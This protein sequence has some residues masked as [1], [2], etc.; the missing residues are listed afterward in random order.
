MRILLLAA[1]LTLPAIGQEGAPSPNLVANPNLSEGVYGP[2]RWGLNRADA[3]HVDWYQSPDGKE[4]ALRLQGNGEDWAGATSQAVPAKPGEKLTVAAWIRSDAQAS[5][6]DRLFVRFFGETGFCGQQG[7]PIPAGAT[8][9]RLVS[10][11]VTVPD[12]A[13]RADV[14]LQIWSAGTVWLHSAGLF[15]GDRV[16]AGALP[17]PQAKEYVPVELPRGKPADA[18][19]NGLPDV[20]EQALEI[21]P[22]DA[23]RS[24][25]LT[26]PRNTSFQTPTGYREDNDLKVDIVIVAGNGEQDL[27]SWRDFGYEPHCMGGFRDG[28]AYVE[29][30]PG[31]PQMDAAG[32]A[33]TCGPGSYYLVPTAQRRQIM[34]KYFADAIRHGSRAACPEEPE[35]FSRAGYSPAFKAEWQ[36]A[37][38]EPW[39]DQTSSVDARLKSERLKASLEQQLLSD[40]YRAA[41]EADPQ[42]KR[43]LLAHS[44]LN[45]TSWGITFAHCAMLRTGLVDEMVA[46]VWTGT[47]RSAVTHQGRTAERTFENGFLEYSSSWNLVRGM[48]VPVWFLMDPLEDNPD[49]TMADYHDNYER[50]L[51]ASLMFPEVTRFEVMP[52]PTRIFGRV[53]DDFATEIT[54]VIRVLTDMAGVSPLRNG[55][56]PGVRQTEWDCGTQGIA[57]FLADS[58]MWQRGAPGTS[59]MDDVYGLCLPL[60]MRGIP[61]QI[62]HLDRVTDPGYLSPYHTLLLSYDAMKPQSA[63]INEALAEWVRDGGSL[64]VCGGDD[65]YCEAKEWWRQAGFHGP[66]EHL[67]SLIGFETKGRRLSEGAEAAWKVVAETGYR[68]RMLENRKVEEIDLTPFLRDS[69]A[70]Y[71][72]LEDTLPEDGWGPLISGLEIEGTRG[73]KPVKESVA[74][75]APRETELIYQDQGSKL[76]DANPPARFADARWFVVYRLPFDRGTRA[77]LRIDIGNQYR[78]LASGTAPDRVR[79]F[80]RGSWPGSRDLW[81][82]PVN[83][84]LVTYDA[85]GAEVLLSDGKDALLQE[86]RVGKGRVLQCGLP[87][88]YFTASEAADRQ[89]RALAERLVRAAGQRY[90]EKPYLKLRRGPYVI[91]KTFDGTLSIPGRYVDVLEPDLPVV[92]DVSLAPDR[93][94]VLKAAP[95][96]DRPAILHCSSCVEWSSDEPSRTRLIVSDALGIKGS[97]RVATGGRS[98]AEVRATSTTGERIDVSTHADADTLLLRYDNQPS[99]IGV[100][101]RWR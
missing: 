69:D 76:T 97:C 37:Y 16:P 44:P 46:Q 77:T 48:N 11:T 101:I 22:A 25:R 52:W 90:V 34:A 68:G 24:T 21:T 58:A 19:A 35:F 67:L 92:S 89:M 98:L 53:P 33:L 12:G 8:D 43:F 30:N 6:R 95:P 62:A 54:S 86:K 9:W 74:P 41:R 78:I 65:A 87:G 83:Q 4:F 51:A 64:L 81:T 49:R 26:R 70:A 66:T 80:R 47:A 59:D 42:A 82:V 31:E 61:A 2:S 55:E 91:A 73:G 50:T 57:T 99:G 18:D 88:R 63:A 56:G 28:P 36:Q 27:H 10:G 85:S 17:Q 14:S 32:T 84:R 100:D 38:G 15:R 20:L 1:L 3:R 94:A 40:I 39:Q 13:G 71:V 45:Y 96:D 23:A 60:L 72:K 5:D 75:G 79:A 29:K 93:V 7:P